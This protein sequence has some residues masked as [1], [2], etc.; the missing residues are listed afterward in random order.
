M[1]RNI[2]DK[3]ILVA[4]YEGKHNHSVLHYLLKPSSSTPEGSLM[5]NNLPMTNM[6][7]DKDKMSNDLTLCNWAQTEIRLCEDLK[8]RTT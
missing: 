4:T 5:A 1:Q 8:Q 2:Q 3:S 6:P 7:N